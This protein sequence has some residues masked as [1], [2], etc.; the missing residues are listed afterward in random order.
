MSTRF[1][2]IAFT[3][4]VRA[5]Q[6]RY[7]S[8]AAN[9][10]FDSPD[11]SH[12]VLTRREK[13]FIEAR[14]GFYQATVGENGWPYVQFRGG[15]PG[16]LKVLDDRTLGYADFRGNR[17]YISIGNLNAEDRIALIL[18]DYANR[19]R[20]KIWARA[21]VID[22]AEDSELTARLEMAGYR[23]TVERA[24]V[25]A[26]EAYD[27]NCPQ[28]ITQRFSEAEIHEK[29]LAPLEARLV[30]LDGRGCLEGSSAIG[31]AGIIQPTTKSDGI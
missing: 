25:L 31:S 20:L 10:G 26:I 29:F 28:H 19:Q 13:E 5:A 14:D 7:G 16:F 22:A 30:E 8:R 21:R 9:R 12:L 4:S 27:W 3:A 6:T 23:A 15:P 17:Q 11:A 24:I 2:E 1:A 18:M